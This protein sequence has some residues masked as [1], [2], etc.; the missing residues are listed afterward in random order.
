VVGSGGAILRTDD[1]GERWEPQ[2]SR[3]AA[4]LLGVSAVDDDVC[5]AVGEEGIILGTENGGL[6]WTPRSSSTRAA[7]NAVACV[8]ADNAWIVGEG[9]TVIRMSGAGGFSVSCGAEVP[10]LLGVCAL[11]PSTAIGVGKN[12]V[13][14]LLR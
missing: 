11:S 13:L 10:S 1:G 4:S 6:T 5:L 14:V 3:V 2:N 7:L 9:G 12:G 8:S